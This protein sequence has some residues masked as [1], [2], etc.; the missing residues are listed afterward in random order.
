MRALYKFLVAAA[1]VAATGCNDF[2][3]RSP[4]NDLNYEGIFKDEKLT[5]AAVAGFYGR[6]QWGQNIDDNKLYIYLDEACWS[7]GS[8]DNTLGFADDFMRVYD[9]KLLRD[10]NDFL[11]GL[12]L[13]GPQ[14]Y[15]EKECVA[16]EW[17]VRFLR[18]W[19]YFNMVRSL[20]GVPLVGEELFEYSAGMDP[21]VLQRK[22][23]TEAETY[24]YI[25]A[26][27]DTAAQRLSLSPSVNASRA[28]AWAALA[29]KS[30]AALYAGSLAR[31]NDRMAMPVRT[32]G[33][34]AGIPAARAEGYYR[35]ALDAAR[36]I[37]NE[38]P[39]GLYRG[40]EDKARNF[41][42]ALTVKAGNPEIIWA[43]DHVYP[44]NPTMFSFNNVPTSVAEG[45]SSTN[46]T[47]VLNLVEAFEYTDSRD[48]ALRTEQAGDYIL[49]DDAEALFAGKDPRLWGTVIYPGSDFKGEEIVFQA[50]QMIPKDG[51]WEFVSGKAGS[52]NEH[53]M[54]TS[55]NGPLATNDGQRNK[56]GFCIRKFMD[57]TTGG[58]SDKGS[59]VAFP[60]FRYAEVLLNAAEAAW[61]LGDPQAAEYINEVRDRAGLSGL[62]S[63]SLD[64]FVRERRVELAFEGHRYWD[65]KRWRL[66]HKVWDGSD[67]NP[68][69]VHYALF[70]YRVTA[71]GD[72]RDG[73]WAF[74]RRK[75]DMTVYPRW[76][77]MKNYY[78]FYDEGWLSRNPL[79]VKNPYQ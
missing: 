64:D 8:P 48:G 55:I 69:A 56:S 2:I 18:A 3:D 32:A 77:Q 76:F 74:V 63:L 25:I 11:H 14:Y 5:L 17:E 53:G 12:R 51:S 73:K 7:N 71:P 26:E 60:L 28:N 42:E 58:A 13:Y 46:V 4:D 6:T 43:T 67:S 38:G 27:C 68:Q 20:G 33:G 57:E 70:P 30:R 35:T 40:N 78:N 39:Y 21:T 29:L 37:I 49:Y 54:L 34:E 62:T 45:I 1:A 16:Y 66:A 22:R 15:T 10:M 23:A 44:G 75:A 47:P 19:T 59:T 41:Y 31:Y 79:L 52:T 72:E 36:R 65:L 24:D 61:E 50:G 9:Y